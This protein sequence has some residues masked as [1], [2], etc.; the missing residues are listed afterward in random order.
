MTNIRVLIFAG[1]HWVNASASNCNFP[2]AVVVGHDQDG[3]PIYA[4]RAYHAGDLLPAKVIP[5]KSVA[6]IAYDMQ[7]IVKDQFEVQTLHYAWTFLYYSLF[8]LA[9]TLS[10]PTPPTLP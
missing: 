9:I 7:E 4:G 1:F 2:G 8:S 5:S 6:Y 3:S 10:N